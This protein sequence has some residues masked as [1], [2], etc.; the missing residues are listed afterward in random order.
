MSHFVSSFPFAD[1]S[2]RHGQNL[3]VSHLSSQWT[4]EDF[5]LVMSAIYFSESQ[6]F[7]SEATPIVADAA[8]SSIGISMVDS[9]ELWHSRSLQPF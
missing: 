1:Y 9:N 8:L 3:M 6:P 4:C 2:W 7:R 5:S